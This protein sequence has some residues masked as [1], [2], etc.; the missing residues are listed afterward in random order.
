MRDDWSGDG[1]WAKRILAG[2]ERDSLSMMNAWG[3]GTSRILNLSTRRSAPV[4][5]SAGCDAGHDVYADNRL[6]AG[7][8]GHSNLSRKATNALS[9]PTQ[10]AALREKAAWNQPLI[11]MMLLAGMHVISQESSMD[12][13]VFQRVA[14]FQVTS[15]NSGMQELVDIVKTERGGD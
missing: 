7:T 15:L 1:R 11:A 9:D 8:S 2:C 13:C 5:H 3:A 6:S 12:R 14:R 4:R 10:S